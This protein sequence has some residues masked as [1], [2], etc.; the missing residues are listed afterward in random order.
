MGERV[1][2]GIPPSCA[3]SGWHGRLQS[4]AGLLPSSGVLAKS[5]SHDVFGNWYS[6]QRPAG[7]YPGIFLFFQHRQALGGLRG[8]MKMN[9][10]SKVERRIPACPIQPF[11]YEV[12][13][14]GD[15]S[16]PRNEH[17]YN[18][19]SGA[20]GTMVSGIVTI[21]IKGSQCFVQI[22]VSRLDKSPPW[23]GMACLLLRVQKEKTHLESW[24]TVHNK[25]KILSFHWLPGRE[26]KASMDVQRRGDVRRDWKHCRG[27][28]AKGGVSDNKK[29]SRRQ[30]ST[31]SNFSCLPGC[32]ELLLPILYTCDKTANCS[33]LVLVV[34]WGIKM[35][36]KDMSHASITLCREGKN[37]S[38]KL[39]LEETMT[40]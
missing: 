32:N 40:V 6:V 19:N 29:F 30:R 3:G 17:G 26:G 23:V 36:R 34:F 9:V 2:W 1:P 21:Y 33:S 39:E 27:P 24:N 37:H 31:I 38:G 18:M 7:N 22:N 25:G 8:R 13:R 15:L 4:S 10:N 14:S 12:G 28:N 20:S 5:V 35:K 11:E 16:T